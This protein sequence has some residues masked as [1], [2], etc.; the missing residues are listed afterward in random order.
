MATRYI[1][2]HIIYLYS[3]CAN[4]YYRL[5]NLTVVHRIPSWRQR[6]PSWRQRIP[7]WRHRIPSWRQRIPSWRQRIPSWRQ[8]IPS[9]RQVHSFETS[10]HCFLFI[11][12]L[13]LMNRQ[14]ISRIHTTLYHQWFIRT[15]EAG[16]SCKQRLKYT[17]NTTVSSPCFVHLLPSHHT[18]TTVTS[19]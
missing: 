4:P 12:R 13:L 10:A 2:A 14:W 1:Q 17:A 18:R 3:H 6:I 7:S 15:N 19:T 11:L 9:W 8:R 5:V 16:F